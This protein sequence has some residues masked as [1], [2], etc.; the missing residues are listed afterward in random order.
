[1]SSMLGKLLANVTAWV[2]LL[3][4]LFFFIAIGQ[5]G[6]VATLEGNAVSVLGGIVFFIAAKQ[7][8]NRIWGR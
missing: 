8:H 6:R 4:L 7:I 1:M 3:G 2:V 5:S